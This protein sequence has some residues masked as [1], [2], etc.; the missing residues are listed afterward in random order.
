ME[1]HLGRQLLRS[2]NIHHINGQRD[3]NRIEN[4][5]LWS[6]MQPSGK[7]VEDLVSFAREILSLYS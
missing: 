6:T 2:E 5:E 1:E 4:L 3:D 7:R